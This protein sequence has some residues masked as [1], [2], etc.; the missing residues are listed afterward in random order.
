MAAVKRDLYIEQGATF[1]LG[2]NWYHES[3]TTPG[4]PGEPY[5]FPVGTFARMQIRSKVSTPT[6]L[7]EATTEDGRITL[8]VDD[9]RIELVLSDEDTMALVGKSGVYDFEIEFVGGQVERVLQG[10]VVVS[11]NVTRTDP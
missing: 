3:T 7:L 11:P 1:S 6:H 4:E 5:L 10:G 9:G 2:F 8:G